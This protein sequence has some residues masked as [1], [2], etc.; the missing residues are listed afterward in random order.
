[1][2]LQAVRETRFDVAILGACAASPE[3]GLTVAGWED[4]QVKR[5][6]IAQ[7]RR[8]VLVVTT[9]KLERTA[10]HR[11]ATFDDVDVI[12]EA[13]PELLAGDDQR[14]Q[15]L[16][17]LA[18]RTPSDDPERRRIVLAFTSS[19][20]EIL[21]EDGRVTGVRVAR[22]E[23]V[24]TADGDVRARATD[25]VRTI[26]TGLV[27]RSVGHRGLPVA[28]LPFDDTTATVP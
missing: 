15:L 2:A 19:P 13:D 8:V 20:V 21:G 22:N 17:V 23:L 11:F 27:V 7:S 16:P 1:G 10:A 18:D 3:S 25:D 24:A 28:D 9:D 4:A 5:E 12:V 6:A 14:S 26:E